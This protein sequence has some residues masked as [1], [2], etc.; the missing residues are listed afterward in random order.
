MHED[1]DL[2][3]YSLPLTDHILSRV[4]EAIKNE[5]FTLVSKDPKRLHIGDA[6]NYIDLYVK[7]KIY[8]DL[9]QKGKKIQGHRYK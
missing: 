8:V 1:I 3:A 9:Y 2:S 5:N 4:Y 7:K 6:G